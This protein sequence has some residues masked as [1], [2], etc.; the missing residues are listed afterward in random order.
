MLDPEVVVTF[1]ERDIRALLSSVTFTL[2]KWT[3]QEDIDQE[4]LFRLKPFLQGCLLEFEFNRES[5]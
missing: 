4:N 2:N 5:K 3:G 1:D